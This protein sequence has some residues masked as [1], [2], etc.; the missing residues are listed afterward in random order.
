MG[1]LG[2]MLK[3]ILIG[4]GVVVGILVLIAAAAVFY[5]TPDANRIP[6][7]IRDKPEKAA[8]LLIRNDTVV[9]SHN[10]D[11]LMPLAST[12]KTIIAI[13]F[14][15]Q[16]ASGLLDPNELVP[17]AEL[18]LFYVPKTDGGAHPSWLAAVDDKVVEGRVSI[19]DVAKGMI[20]YSSNANTEWLLDRLDIA[21]VNARLDSLGVKNH[22]EIHYLVSSLFVGKELFPDLKGTELR[23]QM[24]ALPQDEYIAAT[25]SIHQKLK[26]DKSYKEELGDLSMGLQR[27]WSDRLPASTVEDYVSIMQK[28]NSR[29]YFSDSVHNH[30]NEI[31][32]FIMANPAYEK[33]FIHS[34]MKAGSTAFVLTNALYATDKDGNTMAMAYFFN[35]LSRLELGRL[36]VSMSGFEMQALTNAEFREGMRELR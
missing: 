34:G 4:L 3:K 35:N 21:N 22:T 16:C 15:E 12:V 31:M 11:V 19:R 29:D 20:K 26:T 14:A 36:L 6:D 30:L 23:T 18:D 25:R 13:E 10:P 2:P 32:E 5:F 27:V 1:T 24:A 17:L 28:V 9:A 8:L 33:R 7:L